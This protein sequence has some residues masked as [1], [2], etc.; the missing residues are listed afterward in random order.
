VSSSRSALPLQ[1]ISAQRFE[2]SSGALLLVDRTPGAPIVAIE[3]HLRGGP[4]LDRAGLEGCAALVGGLA[5]EG[6][7]S[8]D[9]TELAALLEPAGGQIFGGSGGLSGSTKASEWKL[10][11]KLMGEVLRTPSY[12]A[13]QVNRQK[14]RILQRLQAEEF[15]PRQ[16][17]AKRFLQMV[18]GDVWLGRSASGSSQSVAR[19]EP[20]HLRAHHKLNWVASRAVI[21]VS[22][23]VNP[24]EVCRAFERSLKGWAPGKLLKRRELEFPAPCFRVEVIEAQREQVHLF[25]GHLGV[26]RSNP[27]YPALV[28]LDHVL[29]Q[30]PGFTNRVARILR[31]ELGLAYTVSAGISSSAGLSRGT[32][33]AYIGTSPSQ[34][35]RALKGFLH[36]M[37]RIQGEPVPANE[38]EVARNYLVGSFAMGFERASQ[39]ASYLVSAEIHGHPPD[40]LE[41]LPRAFAAVTAADI[42]RVAQAHLMP[43]KCCLVAAGPVGAQDLGRVLA[44]S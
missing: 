32:F 8:H 21:A 11:V 22:G 25:L 4:S 16:M 2:L 33:T 38:L 6:T 17:G 3:A 5:T 20:R 9:A 14:Q 10:L 1:N 42:Q 43:G 34:V 12:P 39:R 27:D 29:G 15:D 26:R 31:D 41:R 36:E 18:Y 23:D 7:A 19:I 13:K 40:H 44:G 24:R 30:G 35:T 37:R 28:V